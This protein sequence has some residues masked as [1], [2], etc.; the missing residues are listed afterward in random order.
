MKDRD[1]AKCAAQPS[2]RELWCCEPNGVDQWELYRDTP[3]AIEID[4]CILRCMAPGIDTV[5]TAYAWSR[6]GV[7][8]CEGGSLDQPAELMNAFAVLDF[9]LRLARGSRRN[10]ND[11]VE[12]D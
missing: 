8:P 3:Y 10:H 5:I 4:R 12:A 1:C 9:Y 7:L 11:R 2:L 6:S